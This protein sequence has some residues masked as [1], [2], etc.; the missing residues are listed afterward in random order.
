[1]IVT[2]VLTTIVVNEGVGVLVGVGDGLGVHFGV[3]DGVDFGV[4]VDLGVL[5]GDGVGLAFGL[6]GDGVGV[7]LGLLGDGVG[8]PLGVPGDGVGLPLGVVRAIG[9]ENTGV[10]VGVAF[11]AICAASRVVMAAPV[12]T[13]LPGLPCVTGSAFEYSSGYKRQS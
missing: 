1:M 9:D 13:I 11:G 3:D 7:P 5:E 6:L 8:V 4:G 2:L 12:A 10:G